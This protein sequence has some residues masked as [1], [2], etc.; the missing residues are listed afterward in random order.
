MALAAGTRL[1]PYEILAPAGAGGMGEVYKARDTRLDRTV[2]VKILPSHLSSDPERRQRFEREAKTVSS[3]QHAHICALYD[4]GREGEIDYLV[5]EYLEGETLGDRLAKGALPAPLLLRHGV[6]IADALERAH[7]QGV[8][9]RDLKPGNIMLTKSG[10]KLLDFGLAKAMAAP[11]TRSSV[12]DLPTRAASPNLT[13]AGAVL[14]TFQYMSPEQLEGK[15]A[16][17]RTDIF[18]FGAVLHEMATG[19]KA[20][21]GSS[22]ASLISSIMSSEPAPISSI[23]P[24]T[25][26]ALD[27]LVQSCLAKDPDDRLQTAHDVMLELKWIAEAGSQAGVPAR[28]VSMRK[29]RERIAW[30]GFAAASLAAAVLGYGHLRRAEPPPRAIRS[31]LLSPP[32]AVLRTLALSPDGTQ[33]V[34]VA[35]TADGKRGLWVRALDSFETR[36]LAGTDNADL[37]F[38][39]ADSRTIGFFADNKLK[40]IEAG[41]G[42]ALALTDVGGVGGTWSR[43]GTI[44]YSGPSGP[45]YRVPASGGAVTAVTKLDASRNETSHRYPSFLPDGRHFL[46]MALN[47]SGGPQDPANQVRIATLDSSDDAAVMRAYSNTLFASG[48]LL[49]W[50]EGSVFAQAFDPERREVRGEP[51][52]ISGEVGSY[53][54]YYNMRS[55]TASQDGHLAFLRYTNPESYLVWFDR[56]GRRVASVGEPALGFNPRISPDGQKVAMEILDPSAG[57]ADIWTVDLGRGIRTRFTEGPSFQTNPVWAPDGSHIAFA[58]DRK[59]Q[60]DLYSRSTT[61]AGV[62]E[63]LLEGEGQRIPMD[64]SS[65]GGFLIYWDREPLGERRVG[66]SALPLKS[67]RKPLEFLERESKDA[68]GTA[69]IS[70]DGRWVAYDRRAGGRREVYVVSFPKPTRRAQVST[71]GGVEPRWRRDGRELFYISADGQLMAADVRPGDALDVGSPRALF[72]TLI[73]ALFAGDYFYDVSPDGQGFLMNMPVSDVSQPIS[74]IANWPAGLKK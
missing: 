34:Y 6:E 47:L 71:A 44:L 38:W 39:S 61:G 73:P 37:P 30:I 50:R 55:F 53:G 3:L 17:A 57:R 13:D 52:L 5:M 12:T 74:L 20:F 28:V 49:F 21:S 66:L 32:R 51:V 4:V 65:D 36:P 25:P 16:D 26:P 15:E 23:Q 7:R 62:E 68:I 11:L 46:Y 48:F 67:D 42:P 69:R 31:S 27:R 64:Y 56:A 40:R 8:V 9:H 14:G 18:A 72:E 54:E 10:V 63:A 1:G 19:R 45:I 59:H 41:S 33:L 29:S 70:P 24:M 35:D 58:S 60:S 2:A 43:D 22:Q